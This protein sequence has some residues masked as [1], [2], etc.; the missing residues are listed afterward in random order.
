MNKASIKI[1][2]RENLLPETNGRPLN[3]LP[4]KAKRN[5]E[6]EYAEIQGALDDTML[7]KSQVMAAAG[8]G[9]P[10]DAG[11]RKAFN[12]KVDK[13]RT[14]D[15]SIRQFTEPELAAVTKVISNPKSYLNVHNRN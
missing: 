4:A 3:S 10:N 8:L 9:D 14:P 12:A 1:R 15:G 2:L 5:A 6:K 13:E 11:D 7:T